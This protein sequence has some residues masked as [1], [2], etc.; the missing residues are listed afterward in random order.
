MPLLVVGGLAAYV[1]PMFEQERSEVYIYD[2]A[3]DDAY[4]RRGIATALIRGL[5][6]VAAERGAYRC[7]YRP[8]RATTWPLRCTPKTGHAR[9]RAALR[10]CSRPART[11]L[12]LCY[13][14]RCCFFCTL[15]RHLS[16]KVLV[17]G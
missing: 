1:L 12:T 7:S 13:L 15:A 9:G 14:F 2:L 17:K 4:R 3:V 10:H 16:A 11:A 5:Q 8:I 6:R